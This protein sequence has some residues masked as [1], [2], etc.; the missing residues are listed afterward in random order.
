MAALVMLVL[1]VCACSLFCEL[2]QRRLEEVV[3]LAACAIVLMMY[4]FALA[5]L[6]R[7][8]ALAALGLWLLSSPASVIVL[9]QFSF[10][11]VLLFHGVI[12]LQGAVSLMREGWPR[13]WIDLA[14]AAL[15]LSC[16]GRV[17]A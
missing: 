15:A 2:F 5:G 1:L 16:R 12:D 17:K 6:L 8:G 11:A 4:A 10:A 14:L 3:P 9:I 13:W 7:A